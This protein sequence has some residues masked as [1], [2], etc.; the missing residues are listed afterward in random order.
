MKKF[1]ERRA[2]AKY[3]DYDVRYFIMLPLLFIGA[4]LS[5]VLAF[6]LRVMSTEE[7]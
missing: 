3:F 7:E 1:L 5:A 4:L 6:Y 2:L